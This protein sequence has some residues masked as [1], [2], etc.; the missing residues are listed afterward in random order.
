MSHRWVINACWANA[1]MVLGSGKP[2]PLS[3]VSN[4]GVPGR[5]RPLAAG[6]QQAGVL[7]AGNTPVQGKLGETW[8]STLSSLLT[9][10]WASSSFASLF[11]LFSLQG[12]T[13]SIQLY[14]SW[15]AKATSCVLL[16]CSGV[17]RLSGH[18]KSDIMWMFYHSHRCK[19]AIYCTFVL[20]P[21]VGR[22]NGSFISY[23]C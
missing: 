11:S 7:Q 23:S 17:K 8:H 14:H 15:P 12:S 16:Y 13:A 2:F 20:I 6:L 22:P 10:Q 9:R 3:A 1:G 18:R 5:G 19:K 4:S 21:S